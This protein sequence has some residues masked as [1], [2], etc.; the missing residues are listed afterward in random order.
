MSSQKDVL[1]PNES[2]EVLPPGPTFKEFEGKYQASKKSKSVV[3]PSVSTATIAAPSCV[4]PETSELLAVKTDLTMNSSNFSNQHGSMKRKQQSSHSSGGNLL[5]SHVQHGP[6]KRVCFSFN[7]NIHE[8]TYF[9]LDGASSNNVIIRSND[10]DANEEIKKLKQQVT[11]HGLNL[12]HSVYNTLEFWNPFI[13]MSILWCH[14]MIGNRMDTLLR[15]GRK[16]E[17]E[18]EIVHEL[19]Q[20]L[21]QHNNLVKSFRM[22]RDRFKAQPEST[23]RL[24]LLSSRTT[25]GRQYNMPIS[26]EVAG[27]IVGDFSEANLERDV[28]VEQ[29]TKGIQRITD[30]HPSF[31]SMTYPL[32]HPYGEDG[33]RLGIP[34]R[35]VTESSFKRQK[36]TMR[37]HYYFRLQQRLNEG[38]TLLRSG[39]LLQQY[40]VD[41][42]MEIEEERFHCSKVGKSIILPSSHTGGPRYRVQNYQDAMAI[43]K[44][45]GYPDLFLTFT[46]NPKWPE[47]ND[48]IHLIGQKDDNNRVDI[49]CRVFEIKLFQLM[50]DL[51]KEQPFGKII[52]CIYT[53]EFQKRRLHH[54][55]ILL[56]LHST[57]KNPSADHIDNIISAEI[58]D[59]NVDPDGYNAVNKFMIHGPCGKLNS[60]SP[61]MMQ[62]RCTKH[63]PKKFNDQTTI[64]TDGLPVY[65][66]RNTGSDR[67]TATMESIDTAK[68]IDEIKTYLDCRYISATEACWRIFQFDIHYRQP[69]VERLPFHLPGEHTVIFEENKCVENVVCMPGIEKTKFTQWLEAN[70]N[71][72]DARELTYSDFPISWVWNSK[73]KTWT[74]RKNGLA[75]GRIYFVHPSTRE[76]F[77]LRMLLNFVKGSTSYES[78]RTINGVTY[79]NFKGACYALGLLDDDKEWIDCLTEAAIWATGK[80]LRHLFVTI[81][82]HCQVSDASQLWKSNYIALSE[83][84]TS[85]QKKRF[86]MNDLKLTKQQV[87]A[88]T[89]FEI[90]SIMLKMG[91]SLKDID[92]MPLPN[93]SLIRDSGNRLVN[94]ELDYDRDQL[95]ILHEKSFAALNPCQKSAYKA[96]VHS[97]ENEQV[98]PVATS[99][100]AALLLPNGRTAHSRFYIPLNVTAESTCEF[101]QGTLLAGLLMKTSLIIWDEA[102]MANK[103]CF[104]ALDKTLRDILRTRF[105]NSS[106]KPFGGLTIVCGGD[107]RQILPVVPKGTRDD[108]VDASLNSSYLWPFFKI[109]EL[110]QNMRLYNGSL[111]GFE[112]AKI[113][114]F[115]KWMLQIGDGSLY[116]D[117]DKQLIKLPS[118]IAINPSQDPMKSIIKVI[119]PSLLQKYNDPTYLTE[120]AILTPKNEMVYELNEMIM[121]IIPGE[122]R[123]YF[124][125]DSICKASVKTNDE[126]LLYPAEFL[127][128]LKFNGIPNHEMRLKEGAPVMLLR[129][130][131][132]T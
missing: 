30:L 73:E 27:L 7:E 58:P 40:I 67:T 39:R 35:D 57:L 1:V 115:D 86:R 44:W 87:E 108:I 59:L 84:I 43:C 100:I 78:I 46:C 41:S 18:H 64:D 90:E 130:L 5:Q 75:I 63:F 12:V 29:R 45:A 32:I 9:S 2:V 16:T 113:A 123:T 106:N 119:Y 127:H 88:Y 4:G 70:K 60:N 6:V 74:R 93:P 79:P 95:K 51:K 56:F 111:T 42:Y 82:I 80:E 97:V 122:G 22:A 49:I 34:L 15:H 65:K 47:I 81:L 37:Q 101:R 50:H 33:Y 126:D 52:A 102:P 23:F 124:S 17:I 53:I 99:G 98:L 89:L 11:V 38:H 103:F 94:E 66:R 131:N 24:R 110:N 36:L 132:Q 19:S 118:D 10:E 62:D 20:M 76:R 92:G 48:M 128:G 31:M 114:S 104:E 28:V 21:D 116:D 77:Y 54:A 13:H 117:I 112:A 129:N 8:S 14:F 26:S 68:E 125:S 121:N 55:H 96:I 109:Y 107:F 85:L 61:C 25:D 69:A 72:D 71:Y 120:R 105:E 91:K 3:I 83:D